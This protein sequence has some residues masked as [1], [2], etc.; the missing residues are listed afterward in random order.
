MKKAGA[1]ADRK[2]VRDA[3]AGVKGLATPLGTFGFTADRNADHPPV[4]Q[5]VKSG[6]FEVL[7]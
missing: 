7:K 6:K 4:I 5:I 2:A 3:L 1:T